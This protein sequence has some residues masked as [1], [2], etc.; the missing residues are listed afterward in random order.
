METCPRCGGLLRSHKKQTIEHFWQAFPGGQAVFG[1]TKITSVSWAACVACGFVEIIDFQ[2]AET[3]Y[4][5]QI[6][7]N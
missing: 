5:E 6:C 2:P 3:S 1:R 4:D 7:C